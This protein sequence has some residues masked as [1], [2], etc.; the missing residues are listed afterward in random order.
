MGGWE[1]TVCSFC[2]FWL[3][4]RWYEVCI[5]WE[6]L[7]VSRSATR[8]VL[9]AFHTCLFSTNKAVVRGRMSDA[10]IYG[11]TTQSTGSGF[12]TH[13][14]SL[15]C[16]LF[17]RCHDLIGGEPRERSMALFSEFVS[18]VNFRLHTAAFSYEDWQVRVA[19]LNAAVVLHHK[20]PDTGTFG[21]LLT[22]VQSQFLQ[23]ATKFCSSPSSHFRR[24]D[25]IG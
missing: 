10:N 11:I 9:L 7:A 14:C 25:W 4:A 24:I 21:R 19:V 3:H 22:E 18:R 17:Y 20:L 8:T 1:A 5:L 13:S 15:L 2:R 23:V 16:H 12:V 6:I